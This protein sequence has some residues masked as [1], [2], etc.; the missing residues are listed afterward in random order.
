M[1]KA[2][3][4]PDCNADGQFSQTLGASHTTITPIA[5]SSPSSSAAAPL[6]P[7]SAQDSHPRPRLRQTARASHKP[8][9]PTKANIK[10]VISAHEGVEMQDASRWLRTE[11]EDGEG[12]GGGGQE[13]EPKRRV[14]G[15]EE[16][17]TEADLER[18]R[19]IAEGEWLSEPEP[20][21]TA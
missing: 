17:V 5:S 4:E 13:R 11:A 18:G 9:P 7:Q 8:V 6:Q 1:L 21:Q 19:R 2:P 10:T 20:E 3:V 15:N 16:V 12:G 14:G